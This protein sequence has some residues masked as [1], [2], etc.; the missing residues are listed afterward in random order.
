MGSDMRPVSPSSREQKV[1]SMVP[2]VDVA[3]RPPSPTVP[4]GAEHWSSVLPMLF[5]VL[6]LLLSPVLYDLVRRLWSR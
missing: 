2:G 3:L 1:T 6:L 4:E 5:I